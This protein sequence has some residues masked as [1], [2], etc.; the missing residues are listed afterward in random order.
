[1]GGEVSE[2][3]WNDVT[4]MLRILRDRLDESYLTRAAE[5]FGVAD[6]LDRARR[7]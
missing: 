7:Q 4:S 1:M 3:Q 5:E 2:R 6:L